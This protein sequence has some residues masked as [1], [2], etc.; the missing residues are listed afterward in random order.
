[1][2]LKIKKNRKTPMATQYCDFII[3]L[4]SKD[5]KK[6]REI[7]KNLPK[8][9]INALS[10]VVL[11]G[12]C[13]NIPLNNT[14][15]EKLKPFNKLMKLLSNKSRSIRERQRLMTTYS[16]GSLLGILLPLASSIIAGLISKK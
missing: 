8:E 7:V 9:V 10:E 14:D 2:K 13:G 11:N 16:G 3:F 4:K 1:M 12:L 6:I 5:P 15:I